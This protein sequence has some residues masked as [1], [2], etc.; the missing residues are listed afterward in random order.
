MVILDW[1]SMLIGDPEYFREE[2]KKIPDDI[3][4]TSIPVVEYPHPTVWWVSPLVLR[5]IEGMKY[6]STHWSIR[7]PNS[8][9]SQW[10]P[11]INNRK[12]IKHVLILNLGM[13]YRRKERF[14]RKLDD[15]VNRDESL[16]AYQDGMPFREM[17]YERRKILG[18]INGR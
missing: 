6:E 12:I 5:K 17:Y 7:Y 1:D 11:P 15:R 16:L 3:G 8:P 4:S 9:Y 13:F 18:D 14:W 10:Y 2:L